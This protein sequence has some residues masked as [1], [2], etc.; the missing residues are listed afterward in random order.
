MAHRRWSDLMNT[1]DPKSSQS[2]SRQGVLLAIAVCLI[3]HLLMD[4]GYSAFI[5]G[6]LRE[7]DA[8]AA[9]ALFAETLSVAYVLSRT[10]LLPAMAEPLGGIVRAV[11]LAVVAFGFVFGVGIAVTLVIIVVGSILGTPWRSV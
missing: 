10:P 7:L 8:F 6:H 9:I 2:T 4:S 3:F 5:W 1:P 11:R